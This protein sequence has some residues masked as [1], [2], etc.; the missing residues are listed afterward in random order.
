MGRGALCAHVGAVQRDYLTQVSA[1]KSQSK[2]RKALRLML[3]ERATLLGLQEMD[4]GVHEAILVKELERSLHHPDWRDM[5]VELD[6]THAWV[7]GIADDRA[8]KAGRMLRRLVWVAG[9]LINLGL[10]P[11]DDIPQLLKIAQDAL[12]SV[13]L[14]LKCLQEALDSGVG[15]WD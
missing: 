3:D 15:P 12:L 14:V 8:A 1:S 7:H 9:V 5:P 11:I 4:L 13:I 6:K 2:W 10:S